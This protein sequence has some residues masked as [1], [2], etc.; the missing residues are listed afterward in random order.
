MS[1]TVSYMTVKV[2]AGQ[3]V[4]V[5]AAYSCVNLVQVSVNLFIFCYCHFY[6]TSLYMCSC[7]DPIGEE[8][9]PGHLM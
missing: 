5:V 6:C 4:P 3:P 8:N 2:L 7:I 1:I 9:V